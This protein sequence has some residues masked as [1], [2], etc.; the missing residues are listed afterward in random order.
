MPSVVAVS[1]VATQGFPNYYHR[2]H[3]I[4]P[5]IPISSQI[6]PDYNAPFYF[7]PIQLNIIPQERIDLPS[8]LLL[9]G[10]STNILYAFLFPSIRAIC[11]S[12]LIPFHFA[13]VITLGS[14]E[15]LA[16]LLAG[17]QSSVM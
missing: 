12:H 7:S 8:G 10:F 13:I 9:S 4:H 5:L 16:Y 6:N 17:M 11:S 14:Y 2:V 1:C 15:D 3:K